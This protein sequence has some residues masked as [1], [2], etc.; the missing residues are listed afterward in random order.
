MKEFEF[1]DDGRTF[2]CSVETPRHEGMRPW[3]FFQLDCE[4][5]TRYAPFEASA[6]DTPRS[7]KKRIIA[8][9]AELQAIKARPAYV[10]PAW[11]KPDRPA[12]AATASENAAPLPSAAVVVSDE[13]GS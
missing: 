10:R 5:N 9:Y 13:A 1:I 6:T 12:A 8:Y 2:S 7:V 11:R 4:K 3:W